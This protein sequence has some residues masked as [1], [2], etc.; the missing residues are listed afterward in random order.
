VINSR[1]HFKHSNEEKFPTIVFSRINNNDGE[2]DPS[3]SVDSLGKDVSFSRLIVI[4]HRTETE[5][6]SMIEKTR[7]FTQHEFHQKESLRRE[8]NNSCAYVP[9]SSMIR[10]AE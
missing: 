6:R 8:E 10:R 7:S 5:E 1:Q 4:A 9:P 3:L 2:N